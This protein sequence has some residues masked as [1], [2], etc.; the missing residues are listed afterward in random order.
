MDVIND[1][2]SGLI[3]LELL[4]VLFMVEPLVVWLSTQIALCIL[5]SGYFL[6]LW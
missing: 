3:V 4:L 6:Y 1:I 5:V 2:S